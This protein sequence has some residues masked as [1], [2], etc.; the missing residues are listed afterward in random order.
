MRG[1][2]Q[3]K[4]DK[5]PTHCMK[6]IYPLH[7]G[8]SCKYT[9]TKWHRPTQC[10]TRI[11]QLYD[12]DLSTAIKR[13]PD[14]TAPTVGQ[15]PS[16]K[17]TS[18]LRHRPSNKDTPIVWHRPSCCTR[19]LPLYGKDPQMQDKGLSFARQWPTYKN[20]TNA[21]HCTT[22]NL[23]LDT[24]TQ[25]FLQVSATVKLSSRNQEP[26]TN[27]RLDSLSRFFHVNTT[28]QAFSTLSN[29]S[30]TKLHMGSSQSGPRAWHPL[31]PHPP[32][33]IS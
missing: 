10:T 15:E 28:Q 21:R 24:A 16:Y 23:Q 25:Q 26:G 31:R 22:K 2:K 8:P 32:Q 7:Y 4:N 19:I 30:E 13:H 6:T 5:K 29:T 27:C 12:K 17:D 11:P 9:H 20:P 14:K 1:L 3:N 33:L 18:T